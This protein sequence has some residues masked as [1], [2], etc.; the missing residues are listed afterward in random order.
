MGVAEHGEEE[1]DGDRG[2]RKCRDYGSPCDGVWAA[3]E[4][5]EPK[6]RRVEIGVGV[7]G[8]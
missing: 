3:N 5:E 7:E 8:D 4:V 1:A 6:S 2:I